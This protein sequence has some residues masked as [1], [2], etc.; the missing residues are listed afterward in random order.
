MAAIARSLCLIFLLLTVAGCAMSRSLSASSRDMDA[1]EAIDARLDADERFDFGDVDLTVFEGRVMLTGT[2][3]DAAAQ[4]QLV[5]HAF[6]ADNVVQVIDETI[7]G[8]KT[9]FARGLGDA[10]ID[11]GLRARLTTSGKV[12]GGDVKIAVS[13][14]AIYLLGVARDRAALERILKTAKTAG[15]ASVVVSHIVYMDASTPQL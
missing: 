15:D 9:S 7:I 14:G 8:D 3:R 5:R 10:R 13:Q 4:R 1:N 11:A 12:R 2:V 6:S